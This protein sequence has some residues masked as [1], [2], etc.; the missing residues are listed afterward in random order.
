MVR[1][2]SPQGRNTVIITNSMNPPQGASNSQGNLFEN[3]MV[4]S[5]AL[6]F[7]VYGSQSNN[8]NIIMDYGSQP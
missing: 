6:N 1:S 5:P 4:F 7:M 2:F 3:A 8:T